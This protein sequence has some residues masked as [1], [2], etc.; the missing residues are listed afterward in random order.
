MLDGTFRHDEH[1]NGADT[2]PSP[3][4]CVPTRKLNVHGQKF[5]ATVLA[6]YPPGTIGESES[7]SLTECSEWVQRM[8]KLREVEEA[9]GELMIR[10]AGEI[11]RHYLQYCVR[12]GL[13]P[14]DKGKVKLVTGT[15]ESVEFG[16]VG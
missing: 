5:F 15:Q 11:S 9:T 7:E 1:G 12:F 13:T 3:G 2:I 16:A 10:E 8:F 6:A 14:A 4:E